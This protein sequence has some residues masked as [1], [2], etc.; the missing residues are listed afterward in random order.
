[1]YEIFGSEEQTSENKQKEQLQLLLIVGIAG[2]G[3]YFFFF[4]PEQRNSAKKEIEEAFNA[5]SPVATADLD[6]NL[7]KGF[8]S[9]QERLNRLYLPTQI[10]KFS[11]NMIEAIEMRKKELEEKKFRSIQE[12]KENAIKSIKEFAKKEI[13]ATPSFEKEVK[14]FHKRINSASESDNIPSIVDEANQVSENT[15]ARKSSGLT[16]LKECMGSD[17]YK[18]NESHNLWIIATNH[19]SEID[20]AVYQPGRLANRLCFSWTI[21]KFKEYCSDAGIINDFPQHW[22][23]NNSLSEEEFN[24]IHFEE[25]F[26]G[27]KIKGGSVENAVSFWDMF[28][29]NEENKKN[30]NEEKEIKE[31][32][33]K[34]EEI[35]KKKGIPL[36]EFLQFFWQ[37]FDS[38]ELWDKDFDGKFTNPREPKIQDI[39]VQASNHISNSLDARLKELNDNV[40]KVIEEMQVANN[41]FGE[42]FNNAVEQITGLLSE[43]GNNMK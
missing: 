28:I 6:N 30:L 1:M 8:K 22:T 34:E 20:E 25:S 31:E 21:G 27:R 10:S 39:I 40:D 23:D 24:I 4:L 9:W 32:N 18:K 14:K 7:W 12:A 43:I 2:I 26:L 33:G 13:K 36:G 42:N 5:N 35:I 15:F 41:V 11:E 3:Y 37:K 17:N 16:F 19:L 38:G 29:N